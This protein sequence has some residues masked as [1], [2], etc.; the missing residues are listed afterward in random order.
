[1]EQVS[2]K[3]KGVWSHKGVLT[4]NTLLGGCH[5]LLQQMDNTVN[6]RRQSQSAHIKPMFYWI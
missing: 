3:N 6:C 1:M 4:D 5:C 2:K